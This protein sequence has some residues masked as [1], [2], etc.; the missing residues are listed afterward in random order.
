MAGQY[1]M[2]AQS[3][4]SFEQVGLTN[5][6]PLYFIYLSYGIYSRTEIMKLKFSSSF[7]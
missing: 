6:L 1:L 7:P 3:L 5:F 2:R 4:P